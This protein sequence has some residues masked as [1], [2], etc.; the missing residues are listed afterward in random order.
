[1]CVTEGV[2][3]CVEDGAEGV[4]VEVEVGAEGVAVCEQDPL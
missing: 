2:A 3:V 1:M 4:A